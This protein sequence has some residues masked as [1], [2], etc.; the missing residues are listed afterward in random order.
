[1]AKIDAAPRNSRTYSE[2]GASN[3][4]RRPSYSERQVEEMKAEITF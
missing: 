4:E 1:M 2:T 3:S